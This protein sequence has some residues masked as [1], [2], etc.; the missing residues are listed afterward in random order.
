VAK[1]FFRIKSKYQRLVYFIVIIVAVF[2]IS[3]FATSVSGPPEQSPTIPRYDHIV[4]ILDENRG[5]RSVMGNPQASY[6]NMLAD[7]YS[8]STQYHAFG[9]PSLPNY[10]MLT[11]GSN[12]GIDTNCGEVSPGDSSCVSSAKNITDLIE[13]SGRTWRAYFEDMPGTCITQSIGLYDIDYNPFIHYNDIVNKEE[14]C[15]KHIVPSSELQKD[16]SSAESF[17]NLVFI[18]ANICNDMHN[19]SIATGDKWLGQTASQI[20]D[21]P[22]FIKHKSLLVFTYDESEKWNRDSKVPLI[23]SGYRVKRG[24]VSEIYYNHYSL[25]RTI[26]K[27]WSLKPMS[28]GDRTA[29]PM[30]DFFN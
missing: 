24:Y 20:L 25:L 29:Q 22:A 19:C 27:A 17:P 2:V 12:A 6:I 8:S 15:D 26:E 30:Y 21:S 13:S 18:S 3:L 11:A 10:M 14:R 7:S 1:R 28:S 9:H 23:M 4:I 16:L 5:L